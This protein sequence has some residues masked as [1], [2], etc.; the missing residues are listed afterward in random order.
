MT[1][2]TKEP[3]TMLELEYITLAGSKTLQVPPGGGQIRIEGD[4]G[5]TY[6]VRPSDIFPGPKGRPKAIVVQ[7]RARALQVW[8]NEPPE[9]TARQH[10]T[11]A[12][13]NLLEQLHNMA[14]GGKVSL[15][16]IWLFII[17][18]ALALIVI[19][20]AFNVNGNIKDLKADI[21]DQTTQPGL[22]PGAPTVVQPGQPPQ[23][24]QGGCL[25]GTPGCP[26]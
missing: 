23:E 24:Q 4:G 13:N 12:H 11:A 14:K 25:I 8:T 5:G 19:G 2:E 26:G 9:V 10:D 22:T 20:A 17:M 7:G 1:K 21:A 6:E 3:K 18:G 15:S 16:T